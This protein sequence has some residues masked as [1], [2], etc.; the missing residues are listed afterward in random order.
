MVDFHSHILPAVDDGSRDVE[1]SIALLNMLSQQGIKTVCATP[2]FNANRQTVEEFLE[3]RNSAYNNLKESLP[4]DAPQIRLGAEVAY[5]EGIERLEG[6]KDLC[7]EGTNLLLLEMPFCKWSDFA[8]NEIIHLSCRGDIKI[9][10]A[11]IERYMA[12]QK[13]DLYERFIQND[14]TMQ[15]NASFFTEFKTRHKAFKMLKNGYIHIIGSDC[16]SVAHRPPFIG[17][18]LALIE[19]KLGGDYLCDMAEYWHSLFSKIY[20]H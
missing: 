14:I 19:K 16:H 8:I 4:Q 1:E 18:A 11:H 2:H 13:L 10:L 6:L 7:I 17:N 20:V 5:Y 12:Y 9:A 15:V 3:A